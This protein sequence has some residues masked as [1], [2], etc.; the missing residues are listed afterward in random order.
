MSKQANQGYVISNDDQYVVREK[1][2][3]GKVKLFVHR[4]IDGKEALPLGYVLGSNALIFE[5]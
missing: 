5:L 4:K 1:F 3:D 2:E